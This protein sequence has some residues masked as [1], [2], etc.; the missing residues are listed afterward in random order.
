MTKG[1]LPPALQDYPIQGSVLAGM[2]LMNY[3]LNMYES[4]HPIHGNKGKGYS[5]RNQAHS[6]KGSLYQTVRPSN[7]EMF[8]MFS[9]R[10]VHHE[11]DVAVYPLYC[12]SMLML[13][14]PWSDLEDIKGGFK[15]FVDAFQDFKQNTRRESL[16]M[17]DNL[18]AYHKCAGVQ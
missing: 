12:A 10:W 11:D 9:G 15:S 6:A 17:I 18:Q 5:V 13:M 16:T 8:P 1:L 7:E 3:V 4:T 14:Q 2:N